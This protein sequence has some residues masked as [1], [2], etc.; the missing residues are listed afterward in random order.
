MVVVQELQAYLAS[1]RPVQT[2]REVGTPLE[3]RLDPAR[4][5]P[6]VRFLPPGE[7][8]V[9]GLSIDATPVQ[10][11]L[12][13]AFPDTDTSGVY[14]LA[15]NTTDGKAETRLF[16]F[17]VPPEEGDLKMLNGEQ[18]A[19]RLRGVRFE[20]QRAEDF[21][22]DPTAAGRLQPRP[23]D[24]VLPRAAPDRRAAPGLLDQ[25]PSA[26]GARCCMRHAYART[27]T[28]SAW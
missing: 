19:D 14:G 11:G 7:S 12:E 8:Q 23:G 26:G 28:G 21:Q 24:P 10:G 5:Q 6:Q 3:L 15:L 22:F 25:L 2:A 13:V 17:N 20:Y 9:G 18:L 1:V 16:A 4:Y 27:A